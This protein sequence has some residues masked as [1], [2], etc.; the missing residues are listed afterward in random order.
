MFQHLHHRT[1]HYLLLL[2]VAAALFLINLGQP[3]LWDIDE[4]NNA[5]AAREMLESGN[6]V[7]PKHN[8]QLRVDKPALLYWLQVAAYRVFGVNEFAARLPSALAAMLTVLLT[9]ELARVMFGKAVGLLAGLVLASTLLFSAS[10]HFANPDALLNLCTLLTL[11]LFW[12]GF[13]FGWRGWFVPAGMC[14]GLAMLAK[15]PIGL[16]LPGVIILLCLLWARRLRL[17]L[18]G[19]LLLGVLAFA[20]VAAPWYIWVGVE[21]KSDFLRGFFLKHNVDRFLSP[22]EKHNGPIYYYLLVLTAGYLPWSLFLSLTTW[23]TF[24]G[25]RTRD[26]KADASSAPSPDMALRF[27]VC[28]LLAFVIFFSLARTKLPNYILPVSVPLAVLT[29]RTLDRWRRGE[30]TLPTWGMGLFL[31]GFA[32]VGF[33]LSVALLV[34]G[35]VIEIPLVRGRRLPGVETWA[36]AGVV[37]VLGALVGAWFLRQGDRKGVLISFTVAAVVFI[38]LVGMFGGSPLNEHKAPK[39]LAHVIEQVQTEREVR[40]GAYDYFQPSLVF[41]S[42][43]QVL[44]L[45]TEAEALEFLRCPLAVYLYLPDP[46][47]NQLAARAPDHCRPLARQRDF[48]RNCDVVL[49]TN[50]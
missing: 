5:E 25:L 4:G 46:V 26:E 24:R 3:S 22:M 43:R 27:L 9:Y 38:G 47:W 17:L 13:S 21:T 16:V 30:L 15:G 48:Y 33:G 40:V 37:P 7:V 36:A 49:V 31:G 41:Y 44:R 50:R 23:D 6:F 20:L 18:D 45:N 1:A 19:R 39:S 29:A 12:V 34:A 8:Y 11:S 42:R 35:G 2:L 32:L 28:W 10:A 14:A